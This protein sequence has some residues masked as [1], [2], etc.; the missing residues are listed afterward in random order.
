MKHNLPEDLY[1]RL[2]VKPD[3]DNREIE[4]AYRETCQRYHPDRNL[5]DTKQAHENFLAIAEAYET[6]KDPLSRRQY[7]S[8]RGMAQ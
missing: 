5:T 1:A 7:D 6:L 8:A 2:G 3:V 4:K